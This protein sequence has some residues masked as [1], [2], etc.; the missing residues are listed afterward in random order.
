MVL[1]N[2]RS[3]RSVKGIKELIKYQIKIS[4]ESDLRF[5]THTKQY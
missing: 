4:N 5:V 1:K 2:Y 3:Y